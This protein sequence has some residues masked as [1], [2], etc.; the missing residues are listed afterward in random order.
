MTLQQSSEVGHPGVHVER[1]LRGPGFGAGM[2]SKVKVPGY[3]TNGG[4][5]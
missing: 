2:R 5:R 3:V 4:C 1:A